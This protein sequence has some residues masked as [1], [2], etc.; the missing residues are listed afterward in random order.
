MQNC[1]I[2]LER[3]VESRLQTII[4]SLTPNSSSLLIGLLIGHRSENTDYVVH[5][6]RCPLPDV[7]RDRETNVQE[8]IFIY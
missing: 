2:I 8:V 3:D 7:V 6:A 1:T 4:T 5:L